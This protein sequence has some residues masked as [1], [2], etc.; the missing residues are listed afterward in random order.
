MQDEVPRLRSRLLASEEA[1]G[2]VQ[3]GNRTVGLKLE[4]LWDELSHLQT[5]SRNFLTQVEGELQNLK[6]EGEK[7]RTALRNNIEDHRRVVDSQI[8]EKM[9]QFVRQ[10]EAIMGTRDAQIVALGQACEALINNQNFFASKRYG[11][12][13]DPAP[14]APPECGKDGGRA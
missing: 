6:L 14:N 3:D 5:G 1:M 10:V 12:P 7:E 4:N 9:P 8:P 11:S 2:L 13:N